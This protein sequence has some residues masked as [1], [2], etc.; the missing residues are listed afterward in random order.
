MA[1]L[2]TLPWPSY[3]PL[4]WPNCGQVIDPTANIYIYIYIYIWLISVCCCF[5]HLSCTTAV[6]RIST[7]IR[8]KNRSAN[9]WN[10]RRF[11]GVVCKQLC[12]AHHGRL[13]KPQ[14]WKL[15]ARRQAG[16]KQRCQLNMWRVMGPTDV[17]KTDAWIFPRSKTKRTCFADR[18]GV[19][20]CP[21]GT[22][23][24]R[25]NPK[26]V[27][28]ETENLFC[29]GFTALRGG[30]RPWSWKGPDHGVGVRSEFCWFAST[31][32]HCAPVGL[33]PEELFTKNPPILKCSV[34]WTA[35]LLRAL[36]VSVRP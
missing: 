17:A 1:K 12:C 36:L 7:E 20:P 30:L 13:E 34:R 16:A 25:P 31:W 29:I 3:W 22:G 4:K 32:V 21:L 9:S 23:S 24:A 26:K 27:A 5:L 8:N 33:V 15:N 11:C 35:T 18:P 19:Y 6:A 2:L 28:P 10:Y 14:G